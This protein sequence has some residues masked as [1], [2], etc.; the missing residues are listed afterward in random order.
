MRAKRTGAALLAAALLSGCLGEL[1]RLDRDRRR[2]HEARPAVVRVSSYATATFSWTDADIVR[3]AAALKIPSP[4]T[5]LRRPAAAGD[6]ETGIGGSSSGFLV[7]PD[8]WVVTDAGGPRVPRDAASIELE[9]R[10]NGARAAL[11]RHVDDAVLEAALRAGTIGPVIEQLA[12][13]GTLDGTRVS[14]EVELANGARLAYRVEAV[15]AELAGRSGRLALLRIDRRNLPWIEPAPGAKPAPGARLWVVGFP[16]IA[17]RGDGPLAGWAAQDAELDAAFNPGEV[18]APPAGTALP[19]ILDTNAAVYEGYS[20]GPVISRDDGRVVGVAFRGAG[21]ERRKSVVSVDAVVALLASRGVKSGNRGLFQETY[22]SALDAAEKGDW[23]TAR[24]K[25][26]DADELF[27]SFPD[28]VRLRGEA[29]KH[30]KESGKPAR[31]IIPVAVISGLAIA[32]VVFYALLRRGAGRKPSVVLPAVTHE[33]EAMP[34]GR[35]PETRG[36][37]LGCFLIVSGSRKGERIL[38]SGPV[39][40]IGREARSSDVVFDHPK[41]SRLHAE[42][43]EDVDGIALTDRGSANGTWVNGRKIERRILKDGDI[44][45]FG[46]SNAVTVAFDR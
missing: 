28:L 3:A 9:L 22:G 27:P 8:G 21:G 35:A 25:L 30:E 29:E 41:V 44:I 12:L 19:A 32:A 45:Y 39:L 43:A 2:M 24:E 17:V 10:R 20:G 26:D 5:A 1:P 38:L 7:N 4:G 31:V 11:E 14:D 36:P 6:F 34:R 42:I 23:A 40:V 16:A 37:S 18:V 46:G 33:T 15:S 13:A